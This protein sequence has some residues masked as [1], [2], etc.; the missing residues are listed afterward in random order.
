LQIW[1]CGRAVIPKLI[2][3]LEPL[4]P[5]PIKIR[6]KHKRTGEAYTIPHQMTKEEIKSVIKEF[7]KGAENAKKA[8]FD[9]IELHGAN[10]FLVD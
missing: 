10:G 5:S 8:G 9:G 1:H 4:A 6:L 7:R 3:G 2:G